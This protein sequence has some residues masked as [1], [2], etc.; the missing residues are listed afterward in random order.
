MW[1]N[2]RLHIPVA[3]F[4]VSMNEK[5]PV[6]ENGERTFV[7]PFAS[8]EDIF[9]NKRLRANKKSPPVVLNS[10]D[11]RNDDDAGD[12]GKKEHLHLNEPSHFSDQFLFD[13]SI[14]TAVHLTSSENFLFCTNASN[15]SNYSGSDIS[16]FPNVSRFDHLWS[17]SI[18]ASSKGEKFGAPDLHEFYSSLSYWIYPHHSD[19]AKLSYSSYLL[20]LKA[21]SSHDHSE[22][23]EIMNISCINFI[24]IASNRVCLNTGV[25]VGWTFFA[26]CLLASKKS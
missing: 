22:W 6:E 25:S 17:L 12:R 23:Q 8:I 18:H 21:A 14:K 2:G 11:D 15:N 9:N 24:I 19:I 7:D 3:I 13:W 10:F 20:S 26:A 1:C 16:L 5:M 4:A